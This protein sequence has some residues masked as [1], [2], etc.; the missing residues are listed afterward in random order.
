[1]GFRAR[2]VTGMGNYKQLWISGWVRA[3][4]MFGDIRHS[5]Q[6]LVRRNRRGAARV[7]DPRR[8]DEALCAGFLN[9]KL[10]DRNQDMRE[11]GSNYFSSVF[12]ASVWDPPTTEL[13]RSLVRRCN[14]SC[15]MLR[16]PFLLAIRYP[17]A[18]ITT[19]VGSFGDSCSRDLQVIY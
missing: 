13:M 9:G 4:V 19:Q 16:L 6:S 2:R 18:V 14:K 1:M 15:W 3:S 11:A 17:C 10:Q 7:Q 12:C 5:P 8:R